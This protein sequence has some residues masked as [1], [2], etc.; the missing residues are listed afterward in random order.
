MFEGETLPGIAFYLSGFYRRRELMFRIGV[1]VSACSMSG[2]FGGLL[3]AVLA[4]VLIRR[5]C[6]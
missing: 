6:R 2:A 4:Y 5:R 3:A 1:L